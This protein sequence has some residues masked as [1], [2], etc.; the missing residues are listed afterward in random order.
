M[1]LDHLIIANPTSGQRSAPDLAA[2]VLKLLKQRGHNSELAVTDGPGDAG[3][4]ARSAMAEGVKVVIGCGGDG[5]LQE[6][7]GALAGSSTVLGILPGGRCNDLAHAMGISKKDSPEKLVETICS[8]RTVR[9]DLGVCHA[10]LSRNGAER[11]S[12]T[13]SSAPENGGGAVSIERRHFCTVAT[14][15]LDSRVS[16]FVEQ[17]QLP[18]KGTAA[19]V[20]AM[21]RI[22]MQF[23]PVEVRLKGDFGIYEGRI[24][25]SATGNTSSYGGAMQIAPKATPRDGVFDLCLVTEASRSTILA[26]LPKV[27]SGAHVQHPAVRLLKTK[28]LEIET[29]GGPEW[30]CADG[31]SIGQTPARMEVEASTLGVK[32]ASTE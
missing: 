23:E 5:T 17:H 19:Y 18:V 6:I 32:A 13:S 20:Y 29:P 10:N 2:N 16:R 30:I 14:L 25:L 4:R 11:A 15:G 27:F 3:A 8:D 24:V 22:L 7:A 31:E 21:L 9:I 1:A 26:I 28:Y 12:G